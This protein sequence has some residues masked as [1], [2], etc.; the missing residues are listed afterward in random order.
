MSDFR[1]ALRQLIKNPVFAAVAILTLALGIGANAAIQAAEVASELEG[2]WCGRVQIPGRAFVLIVDLAHQSNWSGSAT[3]P[4][5]NVKGALLTDLKVQGGD[6]AFRLQAMTGPSIEPPKIKAHLSDKK[7]IGDFLQGG[8]T[9]R[10]A[11][12]K[13]GPPQ[14][15]EPELSTPVA[16]EFEGEWVGGYELLGY[17]RKVTLKLQNHAPQ[18]ASADFVIVGRNVNNL[19]VDRITQ[20][21]NFITIESSALGGITYEGQ[22]KNGEIHG[23]VLH[24]PIQVALVLRRRK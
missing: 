4:G 6:V 7:L 12:E 20:Q 21:G 2:R 10:F 14:V 11:L 19:P 24:G 15:E 8:N 18:P 22:L 9:A 1:L 5:L 3:L 17:P 16:K 23:T 13:I